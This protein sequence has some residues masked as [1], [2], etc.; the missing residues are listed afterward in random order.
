MFSFLYGSS[1]T[2]EN[3]KQNL[4]YEINR[5]TLDNETLEFIAG[6]DVI[7][8]SIVAIRKPKLLINMRYAYGEGLMVTYKTD[9]GE[10]VSYL[11]HWKFY[12]LFG[13]LKYEMYINPKLNKNGVWITYYRNGMVESEVDYGENQN[14]E[15]CNYYGVFYTKKGFIDCEGQLMNGKRVGLWKYYK[16]NE[17]IN[18][19]DYT[20]EPEVIQDCN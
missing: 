13:R 12:S 2:I 8:S 11:G 14:E 3:N 19:I 5:D 16:D 15:C 18:T 1:Q 20:E 9:S 4:R 10:Y 6:L 17:L 7:D